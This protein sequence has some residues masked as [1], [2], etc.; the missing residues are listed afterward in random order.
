MFLMQTFEKNHTTRVAIY[1]IDCTFQ[2][3]WNAFTYYAG[4]KYGFLRYGEDRENTLWI[5][6]NIVWC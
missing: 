1:K 5:A 2:K 4:T 6:R 3:P